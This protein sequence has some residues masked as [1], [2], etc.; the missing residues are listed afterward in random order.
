MHFSVGDIIAS[1]LGSILFDNKVFTMQTSHID[2]LRTEFRNAVPSDDEYA[3]AGRR[4]GI[5]L[6][7][8]VELVELTEWFDW[9]KDEIPR[10]GIPLPEEE[11]F[12]RIIWDALKGGRQTLA[13]DIARLNTGRVDLVVAAIEHSCLREAKN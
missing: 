5:D 1:D 9:A 7:A 6:D 4:W 13:N 11:L 8:V 10:R 2:V 3:D 12:I